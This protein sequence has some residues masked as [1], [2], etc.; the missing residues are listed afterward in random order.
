VAIAN[1]RL[2]FVGDGVVR[3]GYKNSAAGGTTQTMEVAAEE[4]RRRFLLHV[5][6]PPFVRIRH[7][8]LLANRTR[9]T[10]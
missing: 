9:R 2:V 3:F 1:S 6:P 10:T 7:C 8:G 4:F 5:V